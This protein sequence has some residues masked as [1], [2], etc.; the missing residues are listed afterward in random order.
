MMQRCFVILKSSAPD[1]VQCHSC[2]LIAGK[3]IFSISDTFLLSA[4]SKVDGL[5]W[6]DFGVGR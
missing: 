2:T 4:K 3:G 1:K 5:K 6:S